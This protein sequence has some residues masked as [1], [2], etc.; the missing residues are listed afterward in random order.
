MGNDARMEITSTELKTRFETPFVFLPVPPLLLPKE[1]PT[2][3]PLSSSSSFHFKLSDK[4]VVYTY[5]ESLNDQTNP[6]K[7]FLPYLQLGVGIGYLAAG[8]GAKKP[9]IEAGFEQFI[10]PG[11]PGESHSHATIETDPLFTVNIP[12]DLIYCKITRECEH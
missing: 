11:M 3:N 9:L 5:G 10:N 4:L 6:Y 2:Y 8:G 12:L 1:P 7:M